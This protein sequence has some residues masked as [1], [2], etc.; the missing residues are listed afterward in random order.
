MYLLFITD[1]I[2][3]LC[4]TVIAGKERMLYV[5]QVTYYRGLKELLDHLRSL[6]LSSVKSATNLTGSVLCFVIYINTE[7]IQRSPSKVSPGIYLK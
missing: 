7:I 6:Y 3:R 2:I 4:V 1:I 5:L